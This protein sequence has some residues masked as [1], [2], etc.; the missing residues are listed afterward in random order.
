MK[1]NAFDCVEMKRKGSL[2]VYETLKG[3]SVDEQAEYWRQRTA[4]VRQ[5]LEERRKG[6]STSRTATRS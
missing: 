4:E 2:R 3:K 5:W 6:K 1:T